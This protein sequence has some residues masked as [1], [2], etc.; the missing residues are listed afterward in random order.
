MS[1]FLTVALVFKRKKK[2]HTILTGGV[3]CFP[4]K[5]HLQSGSENR[6]VSTEENLT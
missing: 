3:V 4:R 1:R 6:K 5:L 2:T